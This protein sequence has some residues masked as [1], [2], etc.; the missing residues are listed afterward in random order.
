M[1]LTDIVALLVI[2][3]VVGA[4]VAY[5]VR[6]KRRGAVCVGCPMGKSCAQKCQ[7]QAAET[8]TCPC[9][10]IPTVTERGTHDAEDV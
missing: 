2:L 8:G 7:A 3:L 9:A 5:I 10:T 4:A 6:E 1:T